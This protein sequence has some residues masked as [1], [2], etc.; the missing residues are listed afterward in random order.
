ML[1]L[2]GTLFAIPASLQKGK[3]LQL[4][5][6]IL[7]LKETLLA[8]NVQYGL[9]GLEFTFSLSLPFSSS[10]SPPLTF[11]LPFS[12]IIIQK[13]KLIDPITN[14]KQLFTCLYS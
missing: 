14:E 2:S 10:L 8:A 12:K 6:F 7:F 4:N 11:S 9:D 3:N 1:V 5:I 13:R